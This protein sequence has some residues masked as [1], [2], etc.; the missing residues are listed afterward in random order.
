MTDRKKL[1]PFVYER[2]SRAISSLE[3]NICAFCKAWLCIEYCYVLSTL[4]LSMGKHI[5]NL[6]LDLHCFH[7]IYFYIICLRLLFNTSNSMKSY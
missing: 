2:L 7:F 5:Y 1:N 3:N 6:P 4:C